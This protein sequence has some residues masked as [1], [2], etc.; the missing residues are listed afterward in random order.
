MAK[1]AAESRK[2]K[3]AFEGHDVPDDMVDRLL[4][5]LEKGERILWVGRPDVDDM[6]AKT[7]G[8][9]A[10]APKLKLGGVIL[11]G[12]G[13]LVGIILLATGST[14]GGI[15][16]LVMGLAFGGI[17]FFV[18]HVIGKGRAKMLNETDTRP[19]YVLTT[20]RILI[21]CGTWYQDGGEF[22]TYG[23]KDVEPMVRRESKNTEGVGDII[24]FE[25]KRRRGNHVIIDTFGLMS[26]PNAK[27]VERMIREQ[28]IG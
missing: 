1:Q 19:C 16:V 10:A 18:G 7:A 22:Q 25:K 2:P 13:L 9:A 26:V 17:A 3:D 23:P 20:D 27:K 4:E 8:L 28:L 24:F 5:E 11:A 12:L 14:G 21:H 6:L 15:A